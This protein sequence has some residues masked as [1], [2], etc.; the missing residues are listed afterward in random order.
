MYSYDVLPEV[1][2]YV[3]GMPA[4]ALASYAELIGFME[5]TPWDASA[6]RQDKPDANMRKILFGPGSE[7]IA[8]YVILEEQRRVIV[9]SVTWVG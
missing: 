9:V 1:R 3:D 5:L 7:G 4:A 2:E 6:Y 8:V